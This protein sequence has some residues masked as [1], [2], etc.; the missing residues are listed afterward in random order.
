MCADHSISA[1]APVKPGGP[2]ACVAAKAHICRALQSSGIRGLDYRTRP[3]LKRS[4]FDPEQVREFLNLYAPVHLGHGRQ[5]PDQY[6]DGRG[7]TNLQA[8][9]WELKRYFGVG[10][11]LAHATAPRG[12]FAVAA[13]SADYTRTITID[14]DAGADLEAR[15]ESVRATLGEPSAVTGTPS[16]GLHLHYIGT[17]DRRSETLYPL[18][19]AKLQ[20]AGV[21]VAPG[22]VEVFPR[23]TRAGA[24]RALLRVPFVSFRWVADAG[25]DLATG[26]ML[27]PGSLEP[28]HTKPAEGVA[29]FV[30]AKRHDWVV[31]W[32]LENYNGSQP[33]PAPRVHV[34]GRR[35]PAS[36]DLDAWQRLRDSTTPA[37]AELTCAQYAGPDF[38]KKTAALEAHG[39]QS[40]GQRHNASRMLGFSW[41]LR[42][43]A[44]TPAGA[45]ELSRGW[46]LGK[47]NGVSAAFNRRQDVALEDSRKAA[48]WGAESFFSGTKSPPGAPS[49]RRSSRPQARRRHQVTE[50]DVRYLS[51][52]VLAVAPLS[53]R[54]SWRSQGLW[55]ETVAMAA[56]LE[57]VGVDGRRRLPLSKAELLKLPGWSGGRRGTYAANVELAAA[58]GLWTL[59]TEG[60]QSP[61]PAKR[62]PRFWRITWRFRGPRGFRP[63]WESHVPRREELLSLSACT[64][65]VQQE[66]G[67]GRQTFPTSDR[68]PP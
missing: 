48:E 3:A 49:T 25:A 34:A 20:A 35:V 19:V 2:V 40:S 21:D 45:G 61:A 17:E 22:A 7:W 42:G 50:A 9:E 14:L 12:R 63:R 55:R 57:R 39:L 64:K 36:G 41:A 59:D 27:D 66:V 30:A 11:F 37:D 33:A 10:L 31:R 46:L 28:L 65:T 44:E 60:V 23:P 58:V 56:L 24:S 47:H 32:K 16:G 38:V 67:Y 43:L 13:L 15:Y 6:R 52:R 68:A 18:L 5:T 62:R 54:K 26:R 1:P 53:D 4:G 29:L 51:R 8:E